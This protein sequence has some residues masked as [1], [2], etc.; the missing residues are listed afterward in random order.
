MAILS[1]RESELVEDLIKGLPAKQIA[2]KNFISTH[3]VNT[4]FKRVK[5]KLN[6]VNNVD[7]AIKYLQ[8]LDDASGYLQ[9]L[10]LVIIFLLI[11]GVVMIQN[12]NADLRRSVVRTRTVKTSK[13]KNS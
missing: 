7:V 2:A 11:H 3:T 9:K 5:K 12:P 4:H 8:G 6:A 10:S 13:P 1:K